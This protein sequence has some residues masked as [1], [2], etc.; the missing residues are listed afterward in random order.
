LF[1]RTHPRD[2][3]ATTDHPRIARISRIETQQ[4]LEAGVNLSAGRRAPDI[5]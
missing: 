2:G 5:G 4:A 3:F 1:E